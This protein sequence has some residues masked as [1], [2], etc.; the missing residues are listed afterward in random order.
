MMNASVELQLE[1]G[2]YRSKLVYNQGQN[3]SHTG[4][5]QRRMRRISKGILGSRMS[6]YNEK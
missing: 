5:K 3:V 6:S 4:S 2:R 1:R